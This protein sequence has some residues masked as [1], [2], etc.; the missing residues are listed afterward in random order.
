MDYPTWTTQ[1][2]FVLFISM[3]LQ[4]KLWRPDHVTIIGW[5]LLLPRWKNAVHRWGRSEFL[6]SCKR[7]YLGCSVALLQSFNPATK[8]RLHF[9]LTALNLFWSEMFYCSW[10]WFLLVKLSWVGIKDCHLLFSSLPTLPS[11]NPLPTATAA[12]LGLLVGLL[13]CVFWPVSVQISQTT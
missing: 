13:W 8:H 2:I 4:G 1:L 9:L 11:H 10:R 6:C 12:P 3:K 7:H 5:C